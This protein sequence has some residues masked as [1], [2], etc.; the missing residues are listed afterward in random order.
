[1]HTL[2]IKECYSLKFQALRWIES[3]FSLN[4][5]NV[6]YMPVRGAK[7]QW[8]KILYDLSIKAV[9]GIAEEVVQVNSIYLHLEF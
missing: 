9:S 7:W 3:C 5:M 1:M 4:E 2:A 8:F 6:I